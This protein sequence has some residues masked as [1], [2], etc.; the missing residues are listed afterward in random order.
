MKKLLFLST[1]QSNL[2]RA[3]AIHSALPEG[4]ELLVYSLEDCYR[5]EDIF[6]LDRLHQQEIVLWDRSQIQ[7]WYYLSS[8]WNLLARKHKSFTL[9]SMA[10]FARQES[11]K[12]LKESLT[13]FLDSN[14][15]DAALSS[16]CFE[17]ESRPEMLTSFE[18][19]QSRKRNIY[20]IPHGV[21]L[22][23]E[24]IDGESKAPLAMLEASNYVMNSDFESNYLLKFT[25]VDESVV[26]ILGDPAF[27]KDWRETN[28]SSKIY[29]CCLFFPA[30]DVRTYYQNVDWLLWLQNFLKDK[31]D[32]KIAVKFHPNSNS[33]ELKELVNKFDSVT[34]F[35]KDANSW[36]LLHKSK[37][38]FTTPST[39]VFQ[40]ITLKL[41]VMVIDYFIEGVNLEVMN[42]LDVPVVDILSKESFLIE[43]CKISQDESALVKY[44]LGGMD[45]DPAKRLVELMSESEFNGAV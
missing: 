4:W 29:D 45:S 28:H 3:L 16:Y 35:W 15:F 1:N 13:E 27:S 24:T 40:A 42:A 10:M 7:I 2:E 19:F 11:N 30:I 37:A 34:P 18:W 36:D 20:F 21:A 33:A 44:A 8:Q 38:I 9:H 23:D 41:P 32:L 17:S 6:L 14:D 43:N 26:S 39:I 22:H 5:I 25:S 12:I 31:S